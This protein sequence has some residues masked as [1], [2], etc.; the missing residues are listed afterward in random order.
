MF[1][2]RFTELCTAQNKFP[3][4]VASELGFSSAASTHWK[5]GSIPRATALKKIADYFGVTVEYLKGETDIK[6][7]AAKNDNEV[8][9][10]V[11]RLFRELPE[12]N[13]NEAINY[14]R[15]LAS[16]NTEKSNHIS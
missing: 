5:Q 4:N 11:L 10:E 3:N 15:F 16:N 13:R 8:E 14:L 12:G 7:P 2:Q 6:N 9:K 1:W